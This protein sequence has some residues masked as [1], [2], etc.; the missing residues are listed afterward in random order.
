MCSSDLSP[1][2]R[3]QSTTMPP[4]IP[5]R[6]P[7]LCC[8]SAIE[9]SAKPSLTSLFAALSVQQTRSAS[10]LSNL[11]DN[12]GAYQKRIKVGRGPSSGYGKTSGRGHKGQKQHGK[13]KP[14]F[15][16]GQTPLMVQKGRLGFTNLC[17]PLPF[18]PHSP[19]TQSEY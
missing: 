6:L 19:S 9:S 10:I 16:G 12:K 5:T 8:R 4:R 15:Q 2:L 11:R 14:W 7:A 17:V 3:R 13:V 18:L 1:H